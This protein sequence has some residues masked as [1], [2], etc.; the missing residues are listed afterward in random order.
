MFAFEG[1]DGPHDPDKAANISERGRQARPPGGRIRSRPALSAG[2]AIPAGLQARRRTVPRGRRR[3]QFASA[4]RA[5]HDVQGRPR[6]AE[7]HARGHAA[8]G[9]RL[10][11]PAMSTPW[12]NTPSP[13]ST[14]PASPKNE[15]AAAQLFLKAAHRGSPVAQD[16]L[17]RILMAGRGL[18]A[19]P[20]EAIKWHIIAKAG[21][22]Q[23]SR[24]RPVRLQAE[25][26]GARS[27]R[28]ASQEVAVDRAPAVV[29]LLSLP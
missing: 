8:D 26:Q 7:G 23:R 12:S 18:P 17:A 2:P 10:A 22:A 29:T 9:A 14:A 24:A 15:T 6:R 28:E 11:S 13:S 1:R 3:R 4:I 19:D 20:T 27:R 21:G 16:R 25:R 5:R